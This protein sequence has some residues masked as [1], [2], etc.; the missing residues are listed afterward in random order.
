MC[1]HPL[2]VCS[3]SDSA[4]GTSDNLLRYA[5]ID[6]SGVGCTCCR[7]AVVAA[8]PGYVQMCSCSCN[9]IN[10]RQARSS[11]ECVGHSAWIAAAPHHALPR[12]HA[13]ERPRVCC[14]HGAAPEA[15]A[16]RSCPVQAHH[17]LAYHSAALNTQ[18]AHV[19]FGCCRAGCCCRRVRRGSACKCTWRASRRTLS[20]PP[21]AGAPCL[22]RG[23]CQRRG[24][25]WSSAM[26]MPPQPL[27][28]QTLCSQCI[29]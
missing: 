18:F 7:A 29:L 25:G 6:C 27:C 16:S 14:A 5:V 8:V 22:R 19:C 23:I 15:A 9:T 2:A 10:G 13:A 4:S 26:A 11:R 1:A 20:S 12:C 3:Y 21:S 28:W 17:L 24:C